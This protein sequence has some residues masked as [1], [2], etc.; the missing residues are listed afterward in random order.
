MGQSLAASRLE[1]TADVAEVDRIRDRLTLA[2]RTADREV[3]VLR[4]RVEAAYLRLAGAFETA[5]AAELTLGG[6]PEPPAQPPHT[7]IIWL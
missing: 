3:E 4:A 7:T 2:R 6:M 1:L 5:F